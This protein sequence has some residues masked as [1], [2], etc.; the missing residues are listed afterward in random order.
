MGMLTFTVG[1]PLVMESFPNYDNKTQ[2]LKDVIENPI[3]PQLK[4]QKTAPTFCPQI[5]KIINPQNKGS[6]LHTSFMHIFGTSFS[7]APFLRSFAAVHQ[8]TLD[9]ACCA[10]KPKT[11][12]RFVASQFL[13]TSQ[14]FLYNLGGSS[15]GGG[16]GRGHWVSQSEDFYENH[17]LGTTSTS[18]HG[19]IH[20]KTAVISTR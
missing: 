4:I 20:N 11:L 14:S 7:H 13:Y 1:Q 19:K 2:L 9:N 8:R 10:Q 6:Y 15:E 18:F 17:C 12:E 3:S 16:E 5:H